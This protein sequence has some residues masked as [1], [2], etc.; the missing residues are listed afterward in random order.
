MNYQFLKKKIYSEIFRQNSMMSGICFKTI[1]YRGE[2]GEGIGRTK[3][4]TNGGLLE[5][6]D[7]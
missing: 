1:Q 6:D 2:A 3:L 4:A 5:L 7:G